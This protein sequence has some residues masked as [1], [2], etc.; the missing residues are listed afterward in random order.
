MTEKE[1]RTAIKA[2][3][4]DLIL[5]LHKYKGEG[6]FSIKLN[7]TF[8]L[9]IVNFDQWGWICGAKRPK[10]KRI[11]V[12]YFYVL[13]RTSDGFF[14]DGRGEKEYKISPILYEL[15][16]QVDEILKDAYSELAPKY[17]TD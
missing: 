8:R 15:E 1:F 7:E 14:E 13:K 6:S 16:K 11:D 12:V 2:G 17:V 9:D 10:T 3:R 5:H 4:K